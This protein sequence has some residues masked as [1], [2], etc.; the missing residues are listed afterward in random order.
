M[1]GNVRRGR[2]CV[3]HCDA[4]KHIKIFRNARVPECEDRSVR[5][6]TFISPRYRGLF[7]LTRRAGAYNY[8]S[9]CWQEVL[10]SL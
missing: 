7:L 2:Y 3:F 1:N 5:P 4:I 10:P 9:F 8:L 6:P